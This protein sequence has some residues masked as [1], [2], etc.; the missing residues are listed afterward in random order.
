MLV[1]FSRV[2]EVQNP[3]YCFRVMSCLGL[4]MDPE[5]LRGIKDRGV[6]KI[7][8]KNEVILQGNNKTTYEGVL[9]IWHLFW[10]DKYKPH[11]AKE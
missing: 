8:G 2:L 10:M 1:L 11:A 6:K 3:K 5:L 9:I 4:P 7:A